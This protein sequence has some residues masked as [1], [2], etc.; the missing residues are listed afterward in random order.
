MLKIEPSHDINVILTDVENK[1]ID[2]KLENDKRSIG[3]YV[4][5]NYL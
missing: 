4:V 5:K 3:K 2:G 1:V